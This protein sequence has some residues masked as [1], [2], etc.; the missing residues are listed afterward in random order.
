[1]SWWLPH[2]EDPATFP[3]KPTVLVAEGISSTW[4]YHLRNPGSFKALCG[5]QVMGTSIPVSAWGT[6][7][8]INEHWCSKCKGIAEKVQP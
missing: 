7:T 4:H 6:K 1:M 8:H 2:R 5:A 3:T